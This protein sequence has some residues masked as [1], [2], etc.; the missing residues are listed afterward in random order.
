MRIYIIEIPSICNDKGYV[1]AETRGQAKAKSY[2]NAKDAWPNLE[3]IDVKAKVCRE[4]LRDCLGKECEGKMAPAPVGEHCQCLRC[5]CCTLFCSEVD[6]RL[7]GNV[8]CN[9]PAE[10]GFM[11]YCK[12]HMPF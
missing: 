2:R 5:E 8:Y 4:K 6:Y 10:S 1:E 3:F 11:R 7:E 12:E 9:K